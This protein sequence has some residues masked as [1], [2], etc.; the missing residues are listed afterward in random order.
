MDIAHTTKERT[1][2]VATSDTIEEIPLWRVYEYS[3]P[4]PG[5]AYPVLDYEGLEIVGFVQVLG[6]YKE[7]VLFPDNEIVDAHSFKSLGDMIGSVR[8][9]HLDRMQQS[10]RA[11][12]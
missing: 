6:G 2:T 7:S 10:L 12:E 5:V 1:M 3:C 8:L 9:A 11:A 4:V